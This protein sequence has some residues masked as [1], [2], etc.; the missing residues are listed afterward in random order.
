M[1]E[2]GRPEYWCSRCNQPVP[3]GDGI[4]TVFGVNSWLLRFVIR[5]VLLLAL[6]L[7]TLGTIEN[8]VNRS[9]I[10][11]LAVVTLAFGE[12]LVFEGP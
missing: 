8:W 3:A 11:V 2:K 9:H 10:P 5:F 12:A 1:S 7:V 4:R 6:L